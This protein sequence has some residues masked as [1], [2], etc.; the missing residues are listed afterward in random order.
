[1]VMDWTVLKS[2]CS[3]H[4]TPGDEG[5]VFDALAARWELQ[6]LDV[7]RLGRYAV[8]AE[9]AVR[10]KADSV[11]LVAHADSPGFVVSV[12]MSAMELK[13]LALGGISPQNAELVLKVGGRLVSAYVYA[14]ED[15]A[16]WSRREPLQVILSE[17]CP[18]V[19]QGDRLCWAFAWQEDDEQIH[20]PFL[21]N[22]IAC[23][24]VAEWYTRYTRLLTECNVLLAATAMEEVNGFGANVLARQVH[25]DAV[26]VLDVTYTNAEQGV[27]LE[28]G[29][30]ITLSDASVLLSPLERDQLS[31]CSVPLQTEVYNFSGT[32]ARAFPAMGVPVPVVP[33][34][35]PTEGN[36]GPMECIAKRDLEAWPG[37]V[38]AVVRCLLRQA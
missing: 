3:L 33:V 36:H 11:L 31:S 13:V 38:A 37:A 24:L 35:L 20:S 30:V 23:A 14:P 34:L 15:S 4:S 9:P 8:L 21:D 16:A 18:D 29:P 27:V 26:V 32:D 2:F 7:S 28:G 25:V 17:P 5:A 1:M 19:R 22:R 10:K 12:V 6:G